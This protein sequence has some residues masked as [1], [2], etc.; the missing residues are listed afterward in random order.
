MYLFYVYECLDCL[1]VCLPCADLVPRDAGTR[2][3]FPETG[4]LW[5]AVNCHLCAEEQT[6]VSCKDKSL[7]SCKDN[8]LKALRLRNEEALKGVI[9]LL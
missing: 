1:H 2:V 4:A 6:W 5:T 3:K 7:M 8:C 9:R